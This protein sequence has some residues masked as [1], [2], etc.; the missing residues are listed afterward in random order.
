[1]LLMFTKNPAKSM[2]GMIRIGVRATATYLLLTMLPIAKPIPDPFQQAEIP[3][4]RKMKYLSQDSSERPR[5]KYVRREVRRGNQKKFGTSEVN[6][7][8]K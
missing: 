8:K 4:K 5:M 1:M 2:N 3:I 6:F 7:P